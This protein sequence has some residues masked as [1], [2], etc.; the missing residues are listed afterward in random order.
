MPIKEELESQFL[1]GEKFYMCVEDAVIDNRLSYMESIMHVCDSKGID[2]EDLV[3]LKLVS[4][5]LKCKLEEESIALGLL[6]ETSKL[7]F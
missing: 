4:P 7:P 6:K 2:P 1:N 3:K 5:I